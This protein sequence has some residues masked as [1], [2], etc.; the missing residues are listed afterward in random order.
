[1]EELK[2]LNEGQEE[3]FDSGGTLSVLRNL[4]SIVQM[5]KLLPTETCL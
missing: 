1:M 5:D 4:M 3:G 2:N